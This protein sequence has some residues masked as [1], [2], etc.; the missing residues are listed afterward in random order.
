MQLDKSY[1]CTKKFVEHQTPEKRGRL[2][3][4]LSDSGRNHYEMIPGMQRE[5]LNDISLAELFGKIHP[6]HYS[7][8]FANLTHD[9]KV[10]YISALPGHV[11]REVATNLG[12]TDHLT[13]YEEGIKA[14]FFEEI[15]SLLTGGKE[16]PLP[17][18]YIPEDPLLCLVKCDSIEMG[19]LISFLGLFD[20]FGELKTLID[21]KLLLMLEEALSD[22]ELRMLKEIEKGKL[23]KI[24][25][26]PMGLNRW[27]GDVSVLRAVIKER[28]INRLA[29]AMM[30]SP[31]DLIWIVTH[32]M[33]V[34]TMI[35]FKK[36]RAE[37]SDRQMSATLQKQVKL[38]WDK[39]CTVSH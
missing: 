26:E 10:A 27:N 21:G 2:L 25:F 18:S 20:L 31:S 7:E 17:F 30:S 4:Y 35:E 38:C 1:I 9:I 19:M 8:A 14:Y 36:Y 16:R 13:E 33:D 22:D 23:D 37:L 11:R 29:K 34:K 24:L 5:P 28:G 6:S 12:I 15:I 39:V 3:S 32:I